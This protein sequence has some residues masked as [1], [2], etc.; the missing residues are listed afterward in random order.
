MIKDDDFGDEF[1]KSKSKDKLY[2][3]WIQ[4]MHHCIQRHEP[5]KP[6][7]KRLPQNYSVFLLML[8]WDNRI[9]VILTKVQSGLR[10]S[11]VLCRK[12]L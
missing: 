12:W 10:Y 7:E 1:R 5:S 11:F 3:S 9:S 8:S 2:D 4:A 6:I